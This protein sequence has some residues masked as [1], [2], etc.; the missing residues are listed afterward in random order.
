VPADRSALGAFL[1]SRRDRLTPAQAGIT[2]FPGPRRVPGLRKEELAVL[3]GLSPDHYSRLEQGRQHTVTDDVV[4]ALGRALR[5]DDVERAHLR[6]LAAPQRR[7]AATWEVAQRADAG[8]LRVMTTLDHVPALLLGRRSEVLGCNALLRAVL[9]AEVD[10]GE[11]LVR[12]LF[13]D[14][15]ARGRIEN[16]S[17]YAAAAVGALR[18]EVGRHPTDR[19][20]RGLVDELRTADPDVSRWWDDHGVTDRT[21]VDKRIAHPVVG[22][23]AFGIEA[24]VSPHD[25]EQR[26]VVYTAQPGSPT[27]AALPV[28]ASWGLESSVRPIP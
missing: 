6:D 11:V 1:R 14:P 24:L 3:A 16:W 15:R 5:L 21:S 4:E 19:R 12:W 26:L 10:T 27:A 28:L 23:L 17:D 2:P 13:L 18:Y 25:P 7:T 22:R 9:G 8:L 20:L